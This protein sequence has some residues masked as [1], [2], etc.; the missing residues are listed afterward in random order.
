MSVSTYMTGEIDFD[1]ETARIAFDVARDHAE[2]LGLRWRSGRIDL[3]PQP[4]LLKLIELSDA[5]GEDSEEA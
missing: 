3:V 1:M 2:S 4:K 5:V